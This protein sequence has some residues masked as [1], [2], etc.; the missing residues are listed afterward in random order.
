MNLVRWVRR[1]L[2]ARTDRLAHARALAD[3]RG[4]EVVDQQRRTEE[5]TRTIERQERRQQQQERELE[6]LRMRLRMLK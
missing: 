3:P 5:Q 4:R 1:W 2:R 6:L